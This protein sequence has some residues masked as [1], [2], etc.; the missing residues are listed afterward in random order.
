MRKGCE[1]VGQ[2]SNIFTP[3]A[4]PEKE[5][6]GQRQMP[7]QSGVESNKGDREEETKGERERVLE[8]D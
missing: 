7:R 3:L 2:A 4:H 8:R 6:K 1:D 5:R